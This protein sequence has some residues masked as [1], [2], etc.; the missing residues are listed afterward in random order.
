LIVRETGALEF[1]A[2]SVA[3]SVTVWLPVLPNV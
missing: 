1:P 3:T 2:A